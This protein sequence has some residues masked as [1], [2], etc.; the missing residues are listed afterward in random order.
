MRHP[1]L[2]T[3]QTEQSNLT[4]A[5]STV[6]TAKLATRSSPSQSSLLTRRVKGPP[7]ENNPNMCKIKRPRN[8]LLIRSFGKLNS[9]KN[10][11]YRSIMINKNTRR[12]MPRRRSNSKKYPINTRKKKSSSSSVKATIYVKIF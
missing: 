5:T 8:T 1:G 3:P 11:Y 6:R 4:K 10:S 7:S 2:S 9:N 12:T